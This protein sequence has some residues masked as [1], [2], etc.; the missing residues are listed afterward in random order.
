[1]VNACRHRGAP[2]LDRPRRSAS[3][4]SP[5]RTTAGRTE[6]DGILTRPAAVRRRVRRRGRRTADLHPARRRRAL[7]ADLRAAGFGDSIDVDAVPPGAEDDLAVFDSPPRARRDAATRCGRRTGSSS[8]TRSPS[9]TTSAPCTVDACSR[10]STP[11][12]RSSRRSAPTCSTRV[13][14]GPARRAD[15]AGGGAVDS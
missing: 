7:R 13:S 1:M 5:A 10:R 4:G 6:L 2:V 11:I 14:Q 12:A 8:S 3:G 9:R 15:Q